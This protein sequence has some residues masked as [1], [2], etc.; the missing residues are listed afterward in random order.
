MAAVS[1]IP[2]Q[3][4]PLVFAAVVLRIALMAHGK[5][6]HERYPNDYNVSSYS[7]TYSRSICA[8]TWGDGC[9]DRIYDG[10]YKSMCTESSL[11]GLMLLLFAAAYAVPQGVRMYYMLKN[12]R[13]SSLDKAAEGS[14]V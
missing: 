9:G 11:Y 1:S 10:D 3:F 7:Y 14:V 8:A 5:F 6:G 2:P 12:R 13:S 4:R